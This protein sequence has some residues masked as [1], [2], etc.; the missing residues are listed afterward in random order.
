M[1]LFAQAVFPHA[2]LL[3]QV[4][5]IFAGEK[6]VGERMGAEAGAT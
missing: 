1:R 4:L 2:V 5:L 3:V 6:E